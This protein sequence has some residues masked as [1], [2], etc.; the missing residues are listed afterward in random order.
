MD[1]DS[2]DVLPK[3]PQFRSQWICVCLFFLFVF[4]ISWASHTGYT[5]FILLKR[6]IIDLTEQLFKFPD[7]LKQTSQVRQKGT[8]LLVFETTSSKMFVIFLPKFMNK[9]TNGMISP[10]LKSNTNISFLFR[11]SRRFKGYRM[12][13]KYVKNINSL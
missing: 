3:G 4:D 9:Q 12:K 13:E 7:E 2:P 1:R 5:V 8:V 10:S 6:D 11:G